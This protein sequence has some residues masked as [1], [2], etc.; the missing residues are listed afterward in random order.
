MTSELVSMVLALLTYG[1]GGAVAV[2]AAVEDSRSGRLRNTLTTA[3]AGIAV[4]GFGAA[5]LV[6]EDGARFLAIVI[7]S[8]LFSVPWFVSHL[9]NPGGIGF[10]DVKLTAGLGLYLGWIDPLLS[11]IAVVVAAVLFVASSV[12]RGPDAVGHG[13]DAGRRERT[14]DPPV[15]AVVGRCRCGGGRRWRIRRVTAG[16]QRFGPGTGG[17]KASDGGMATV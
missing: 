12:L 3:I 16:R 17:V 7:G 8:V 5:A 11:P 4:V 6:A 1:A 10:G 9:L 15:W 14:R 13:H 2:V